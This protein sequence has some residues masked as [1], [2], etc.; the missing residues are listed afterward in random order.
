MSILQSTIGKEITD[1]KEF[2]DEDDQVVR[3]IIE[4]SDNS[5][6]VI[7]CS[8]YNYGGQHLIIEE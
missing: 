6:V 4:F 2:F 1:V 8:S 5:F 3:T 7:S